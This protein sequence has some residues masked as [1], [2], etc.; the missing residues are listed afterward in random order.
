MALP[1]GIK[2]HGAMEAV[3]AAFRKISFNEPDT[4]SKLPENMRRDAALFLTKTIREAI[5]QLLVEPIACM[6]WLKDVSRVVAESGQP[7]KWITPSGFP[8]CAAY[9]KTREITVSTRLDATLIDNR[10]VVEET[11]QIN[12]KAIIR[13]ISANF[14]HSLDASIAHL[15]C[16]KAQQSAIHFAIVHDC[17]VAHASDLA[18]LAEIVKS[19]YVSVFTEN[20]LLTFYKQLVCQNPK[21]AENKFYEVRDFPVDQIMH[22]KYFLS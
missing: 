16:C 8:V 18:R 17:F 22:S 19:T 20:Q 3:D 10:C 21:V 13:A 9:I 15:V 11:K 14:V 4:F 12:D 7:V 2:P 5:G 1:Y 6:N